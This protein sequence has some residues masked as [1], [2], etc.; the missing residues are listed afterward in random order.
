MDLTMENQPQPIVLKVKGMTCPSC[1]YHV[2][3]AVLSLEGVKTVT[4]DNWRNGETRIEVKPGTVTP[5]QIAK[6][7]WEAG[8]TPV[9]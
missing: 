5:E 1:A 4:I 2:Q 6:A 3:E 8:Y 9:P 7:I